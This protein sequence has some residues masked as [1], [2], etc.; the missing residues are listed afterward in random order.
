MNR[1]I[2]GG[3]YRIA[4]DEI[5]LRFFLLSQRSVRVFDA[6]TNKLI[7]KLQD[8][9]NPNQ[10]YISQKNNMI[11]VKSTVGQFSF[12][13]VEDF[14]FLGKIKMKGSPNTDADFYYDEEENLLYGIVNKNLNQHVYCVSPKT[15][16]YFTLPLYGMNREAQEGEKPYTRYAFHKHSDGSFY[17]IRNFYAVGSSQR[18]YESSYGRYAKEGNAL[19]LKEQIFSTTERR[20]EL[21]DIVEK[22]ASAQIT[23]FCKAL[24]NRQ[25]FFRSTYRNAR[26]L[27]LVTNKAVYRHAESGFEEVYRAEYLS[28]YAEFSGRRYICTWEWCLVQTIKEPR[29]TEQAT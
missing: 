6:E 5:R 29:A 3:A 1:K 11:A 19:A 7:T 15:L 22:E 2:S 16:D 8:I 25:E 13:T 28:D 18:I 24:K 23:D 12:Y 20:L 21:L 9:S 26:G 14:S 27:F 4:F 10:I 17:L